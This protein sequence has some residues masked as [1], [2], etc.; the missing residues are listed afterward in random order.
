[1]EEF[2][3]D[4]YGRLILI[5]PIDGDPNGGGVV[6][7]VV[8]IVGVWII[9]RQQGCIKFLNTL[10]SSGTFGDKSFQSDPQIIGW[11]RSRGKGQR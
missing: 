9:V 1:M 11:R 7:I 6:I 5:A 4:K 8:V 10:L 3:S 2:I